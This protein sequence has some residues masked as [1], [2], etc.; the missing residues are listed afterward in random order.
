MPSRRGRNGSAAPYSLKEVRARDAEPGG[1]GNVFKRN[2]VLNLKAV[3]RSE[4]PEIKLR[5]ELVEAV[6]AEVVS[7]GQSKI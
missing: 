2:H 5:T 7:R 6:A 4:D 1:L 3:V